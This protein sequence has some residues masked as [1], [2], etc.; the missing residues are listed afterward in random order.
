MKGLLLKDFYQLWKYCRMF[1]LCIAV[2]LAMIFVS[3]EN[4][5]F[6]LYPALL[7]GI[8]P[9]TLFS[10]DER[11]GWKQFSAAL[12]CSRAQIVSGKYLLGVILETASIVLCLAATAAR[13]GASGGEVPAM[14]GLLW[15]VGFFSPS[16]LLPVVFALGAEK[17][18]VVYLVILALIAGSMAALMRAS[19]LGAVASLSPAILGWAALG[20]T[21][22]Y[23]ASWLL[24][25]RIYQKKEL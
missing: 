4:L 13:P 6:S 18:R 17:G 3:G 11:S 1:L 21:A 14:A 15:C 22:L 9:V 16:I 20:V 2:F 23:A 10:Y 19:S 7:C 12:P 24:S 25:I 8:L 5:F